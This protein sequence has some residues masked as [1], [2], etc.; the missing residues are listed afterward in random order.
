MKQKIAVHII[1]GFLGA[2]KTTFISQLLTTKTNNDNWIVILN[3]AGATHYK[4]Q[5]LASQGIIVKE[6]YGGCL[7]CSAAMTFRVELNKLIKEHQPQRIFVEPAGAGHLAN[8]KKLLQGEFYQPILTL[9]NT[10][11]LLAHWQLTDK[12]FNENKHYL[13]LL[14][15]A[16]KLCFY[17]HES[18]YLAKKIATKYSK[19]LYKLQYKIADLT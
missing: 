11:C 4:K 17:E 1:S 14:K 5:Q 9:H 10:L 13:D 15:Q 8:I 12:K 6:L 16:D 19:P 3:E 2:G 7:C 18:K